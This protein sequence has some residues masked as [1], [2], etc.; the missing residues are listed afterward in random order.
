MKESPMFKVETYRAARAV[1][2]R[3]LIDLGRLLLR[4][5]PTHLYL[6]GSLV[7][8]PGVA[9]KLTPEIVAAIM[10]EMGR[11]PGVRHVDAQFDNWRQ[12]DGLGAWQAIERHGTASAP[13][14]GDGTRSSGIFNI[15]I[16][17]Q[18]PSG[19]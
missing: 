12:T 11:V 7:R 5:S 15:D 6:R 4:L 16:R 10:T 3:H 19:E 13:L 17:D 9:A 1:L 8:L 2:V 14:M 18:R